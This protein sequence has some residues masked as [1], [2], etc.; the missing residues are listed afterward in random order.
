MKT[1]KLCIP[2]ATLVVFNSCQNDENVVTE[3]TPANIQNQQFVQV[4]DV[5]NTPE[6]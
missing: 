6:I 3:S 4:I 2:I 1:F 5:S